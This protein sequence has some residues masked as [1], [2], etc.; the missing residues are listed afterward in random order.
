MSA[1]LLLMLMQPVA[2]GQPEA[3]ESVAAGREALDYWWPWDYPWYDSQTDGVRRVEI[4][5]PWD[6]S[7]LGQ[8]RDAAWEWIKGLCPDWLSDFGGWV[9]DWV[10]RFW[11]WLTGPAWG[12]LV[13]RPR[14]LWGWVVRITLAM[15][16]VVGLYFLARAGRRWQGRRGT[17]KA[18][19]AA[20]GD[21]GDAQRIEALPFPVR[22]GRLDLLG[23][24]LR[25]YQQ[26]DYR[27]A[28]VYLFSFQLVQLDR[29][30]VI[31]LT[32]GKTNRQYLRE[33]GPRQAL[34][35]L[36]GQTMVVFE[37]VFFGDYPL[38]HARF[39]LCWARLEEFRSL[40]A[41]PAG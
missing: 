33:I 8:W 24:A 36:V 27:Q 15:G 35:R 16:L 3:D 23:E 1:V 26:G 14:S 13:S 2:L 28:I 11:S 7:W 19:M 6:W 29:H 31:R 37:D 40:A 30:Q 39:E 10:A 21:P 5:E 17:S 38:D 34:A 22:P 12:A 18:V 25:H 20:A 9:A 41:E 32:K 4:R